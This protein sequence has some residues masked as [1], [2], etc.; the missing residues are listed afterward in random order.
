MLPG[1]RT[2]A[3][4]CRPNERLLSAT[5]AVGFAG[6]RPPA[7]ALLGRIVSR[8]RLTARGASVTVRLPE[9]TALVQLQLVC[10]RA[11]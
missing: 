5:H 11:A 4:S 1:T 2:V 7:A 9:R 10:G 8:Q 6:A 3:H